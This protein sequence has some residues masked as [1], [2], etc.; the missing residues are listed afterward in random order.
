M[1]DFMK[2][3]CK[4]CSECAKTFPALQAFKASWRARVIMVGGILLRGGAAVISVTCSF[5][6]AQCDSGGPRCSLIS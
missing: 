3:V 2:V 6:I 4:S 1:C 5:L